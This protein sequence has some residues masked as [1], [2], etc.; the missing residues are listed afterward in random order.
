[1][2][3]D[4]IPQSVVQAIG[5]EAARDLEQ[6]ILKVI[7]EEA[8]TQLPISGFVARQKVNSLLVDRVSDMLLSGDPVLAQR[9]NG[10]LVWRVPIYLTAINKGRI[11]QVGTLDVDVQ[12][13]DISFTQ[14]DLLNIANK[15]EQL[16]REAGL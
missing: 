10:K 4:P 12:F 3:L 9:V 2:S 7:A 15:A 14:N 8:K 6:W 5:H 1:M 11:G 13:G 16:A